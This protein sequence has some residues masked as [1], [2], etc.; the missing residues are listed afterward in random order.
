MKLRRILIPVD[1]SERSTPALQYGLALARTSGAE[2]DLVH[3][4]PSPGR[5]ATAVDA[6]LGRP[7][8]HTPE[9]VVIHARDQLDSLLSSIDHAGIIVHAHVSSGD[10][11]ATIVGLAAQLPGDLIVIGTHAR[12]L[13][14]EAALGSVA[15]SLIATAP[16]PVVTMRAEAAHV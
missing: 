11:A 4:V 2:V 9:E 16:C 6:Y 1:F 10:P 3:V 15:R 7:L 8:P 5:V 12:S 14:G 13:L